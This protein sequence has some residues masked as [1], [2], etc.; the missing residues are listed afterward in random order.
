MW[1]SQ[2]LHPVR[3]SGSHPGPKGCGSP[4]GPAGVCMPPPSSWDLRALSAVPQ[5]FLRAVTPHLRAPPSEG[6][7]GLSS[8]T[9]PTA[10]DGAMGEGTPGGTRAARGDPDT[11]MT[12]GVVPPGGPSSCLFKGY[13][14][15]PS[16]FRGGL[17]GAA[18]PGPPSF[19]VHTLFEPCSRV[20][21]TSRAWLSFPG[22][23][24]THK[25]G[26]SCPLRLHLL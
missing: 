3:E 18:P 25:W 1:A 12:W 7:C 17:L 20:P 22:P 9:P 8:G 15:L 2:Q 16:V 14:P 23:S 24:L 19:C 5:E 13:W 6:P 26:G 11:N 4:Q 21:Q 10:Q